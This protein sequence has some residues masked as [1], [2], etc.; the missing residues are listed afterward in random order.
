MINWPT[1]WQASVRLGQKLVSE[2]VVGKVYRFQFRNPDSMVRS[3]T[4]RS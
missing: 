3:L 4:A 1:T 2:G